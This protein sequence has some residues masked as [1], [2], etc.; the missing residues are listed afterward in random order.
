MAKEKRNKNELNR[1]EF[2]VELG[3]DDLDLR[4]E[5]DLTEEQMKN[6][7]KAK[8]QSENASKKR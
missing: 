4:E 7:H 3:P 8:Q 1:E 6:S 2:G 5:N